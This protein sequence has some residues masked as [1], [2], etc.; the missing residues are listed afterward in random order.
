MLI[1]QKKTRRRWTF[2]SELRPEL[3]IQN[4]TLHKEIRPKKKNSWG[5]DGGYLEP[6]TTIYKWMFGE[7]TISYVKIGNHPIE[8]TIYKWLF[9]VP[10][11]YPFIRPC[12]LGVCVASGG[13][14]VQFQRCVWGHQKNRTILTQLCKAKIL[15]KPIGPTT[16]RTCVLSLWWMLFG[17]RPQTWWEH[18]CFLNYVEM[19]T[20]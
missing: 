5:D 4:A 6:Q 9:G 1:F 7:T 3:G 11:S 17:N 8:T 13:C 2:E 15:S 20:Q 18:L 14:V 16:Q 19:S 12:F 10:G